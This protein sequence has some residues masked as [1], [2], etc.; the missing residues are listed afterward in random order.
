MTDLEIWWLAYLAAL[1][2]GATSATAR[3]MASGAVDDYGNARGHY[4]D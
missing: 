1:S 2:S 3:V 4:S